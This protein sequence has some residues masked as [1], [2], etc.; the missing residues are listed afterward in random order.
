[1]NLGR[2]V[3]T[4]AGAIHAA[5]SPDTDSD[6]IIWDCPVC[7]RNT[8][9]VSVFSQKGRRHAFFAHSHPFCRDIFLTGI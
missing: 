9:A 4:S 6:D 2:S 8:K 1:M 7:G 5:I 3:F